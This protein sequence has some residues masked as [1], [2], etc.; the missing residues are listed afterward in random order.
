VQKYLKFYPSPF[1]IVG[2]EV[3]DAVFWIFHRWRVGHMAQFA[4]HI[5]HHFRVGIE[6]GQQSFKLCFLCLAES[7]ELVPMP[8]NGTS[9]LIEPQLTTH[10][11]EVKV[12]QGIDHAGA[13][14]CYPAF[15]PGIGWFDRYF[16]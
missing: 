3:V 4:V 16:Y 14:K 8:E 12:F 10:F 7:E 9:S 1:G 13:D 5:V 11:V 6:E 2:V 15:S